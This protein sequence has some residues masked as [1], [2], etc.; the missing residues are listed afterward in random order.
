MTKDTRPAEMAE[1]E[2]DDVNGG[3]LIMADMHSEPV[4]A[5]RPKGPQRDGFMIGDEGDHF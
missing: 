4:K 2:M 5:K 3:I 1:A